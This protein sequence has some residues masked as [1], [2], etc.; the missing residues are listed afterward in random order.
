MDTAESCS[1][2]VLPPERGCV[3]AAE[4]C[5]ALVLPPEWGCVDTVESC[6]ALVLPA[7]WGSVDTADSCLALV[8][9]LEWGSV[10]TAELCSALVLVHTCTRTGG[11]AAV[12]RDGHLHL[13]CAHS[14]ILCREEG[15]LSPSHLTGDNSQAE[16]GCV[17]CPRPHS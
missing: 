13:Q 17:I 3:D 9:L 1:A 5:S 11:I 10:D 7:E 16:E 8:L 12:N 14:L 6:S 2:L 15:V 4:S